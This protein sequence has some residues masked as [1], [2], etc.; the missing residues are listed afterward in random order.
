MIGQVDSPLKAKGRSW[1][2]GKGMAGEPLYRITVQAIVYV[3]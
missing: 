1:S 3:M 2:T